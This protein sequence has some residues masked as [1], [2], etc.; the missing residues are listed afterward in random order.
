MQ[1]VGIM[2][3]KRQLLAPLVGMPRQGSVYWRVLPGGLLFR[4][5]GLAGRGFQC[6]EGGCLQGRSV[7]CSPVFGGVFLRLQVFVLLAAYR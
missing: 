3:L 5:A 4:L 7:I 2:V 6:N 1:R